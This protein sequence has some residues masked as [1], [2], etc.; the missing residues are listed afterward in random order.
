MTQSGRSVF[1]VSISASKISC[2]DM[3]YSLPPNS[4][5][6]VV[7]GMVDGSVV[8]YYGYENL[9]GDSA[10]RV[11]P[12]S[13]RYSKKHTSEV[14]GVGIVESRS[15]LVVVSASRDEI[16]TRYLLE[17]DGCIDQKKTNNNQVTAL[18]AF[19]GTK[20]A[21]AMAGGEIVV[22]ELESDPSRSKHKLAKR[23]VIQTSKLKC[24]ETTTNFVGLKMV[25]QILPFDQIELVDYSQKIAFSSAKTLAIF[26]TQQDGSLKLYY[27]K[28]VADHGGI[29]SIARQTHTEH[30]WLMRDGTMDIVLS[31]GKHLRKIAKFSEDLA[32]ISIFQQQA[33]LALSRSGG[34]FLA[35]VRKGVIYSDSVAG[36]IFGVRE[37]NDCLFVLHEG[38]PQNLRIPPSTSLHGR[39]VF[40]QLIRDN[41][42]FEIPRDF[43]TPQMIPPKNH[44]QQVMDTL[45]LWCSSDG[46]REIPSRV[47]RQ[48][49]N[50]CFYLATAIPTIVPSSV[51]QLLEAKMES[52]PDNAIYILLKCVQS[53]VPVAAD[54][55]KPTMARVLTQC[56]LMHWVHHKF[57]LRVLREFDKSTREKIWEWI[58]SAFWEMPGSEQ[59]CELCEE[60]KCLQ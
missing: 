45:A 9:A 58:V 33:V 24:M 34:F 28:S 19:D 3:T 38:K 16:I 8:S 36:R 27:E 1:L 47:A 25:S 46:M 14:I 20:V 6:V 23:Q 37:I 51:C 7:A 29:R 48:L 11:T 15:N 41:K 40:S 49:V 50:E 31:G 53:M 4:L 30:I 26:Q 60:A 12:W 5:P 17:P 44:V 42:T 59:L 55:V 56:Y 52:A 2:M 35:D 10:A 18:V 22:F 32:S 54:S 57:V 39:V 43:T 13:T 21:V